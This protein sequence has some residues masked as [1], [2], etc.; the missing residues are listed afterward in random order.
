MK[1]FVVS[2]VVAAVACF[3]FGGATAS[4]SEEAT[5]TKFSITYPV[6]GATWTC[7]GT[8]FVNDDGMR[9]KETCLI[10]GDLTGYSRGTFSSDPRL[11]GTL[12]GC[13]APAGIGIVFGFK[14]CWGSDFD[15]ALATSWT[16][17]FTHKRAVP[18][19]FTFRLTAFYNP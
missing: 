19:A 18:D 10:T 4:A 9:D 14:T 1:R 3:G 8:R 11:T 17:K 2:L 12:A 15:G 7:S 16:Q 6:G 5:H 13:P